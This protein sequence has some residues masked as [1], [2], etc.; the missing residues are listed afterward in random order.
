MILKIIRCFMGHLL[1]SVYVIA[2]VMFC[3]NSFVC[4]Q[5]LEEKA[6][7][8][9]A[10]LDRLVAQAEEREIDVQKERMTLRTA[11]LFLR[12][13]KWDQTH[14]SANAEYFRQLPNFKADANSLAEALP[15]FERRQVI[16]ILDDAIRRLSLTL[17]GIHT[18]GS[19]QNGTLKI[20]QIV[21]EH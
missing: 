4:A 14:M 17:D 19:L 7:E 3:T 11:A 18:H 21:Q 10:A 9:V 8:G 1:K 15:D 13:A 6:R 16:E 2:I 5:V 12:Y 20:W